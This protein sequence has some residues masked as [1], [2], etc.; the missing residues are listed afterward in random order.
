[1]GIKAEAWFLYAHDGKGSRRGSF[2]RESYEIPDLQPGEILAAPIYGSWEA[3]MDHALQRNPV[4]VCRRRGEE[5]VVLGNCGVLRVLDV[6]PNVTLV[7]PD[8]LVVM[9]ASSVID[10]FGFP[11]LIPAFD[12]PNTIGCLSTKMKCREH[13]VTPIPDDTKHPL[14]RWG[15][16]S[17]KHFTA[18]S[19]WCCL[20]HL[21]SDGR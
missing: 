19:N 5:R 21:S 6:G 3:N 14:K 18:W 13:E 7:E 17:T 16:F 1:M 12:S 15:A 11:K 8:Q 20:R 9:S 4:D 2:V 10:Q